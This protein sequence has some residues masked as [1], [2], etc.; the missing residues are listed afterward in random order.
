MTN[1]PLRFGLFWSGGPMSYLRYLTFKSLRHHHP[2]AQIDLYISTSFET[3]T[4][5]WIEKQDFQND[6]KDDYLPKLSELNVN[7]EKFE[8]YCDF[9]PNYQS[10]FFRWFYLKEFGGFYLDT[11]QIILKSFEDLP[12]DHDFIYCS[13][14]TQS[15]GDYYPVGV[16]G[17]NK[18]SKL[19]NEVYELLPQYTN[20]KDYN[21]LGPTMFKSVYGGKKWSEKHFNA[22]SSYFYPIAESHLTKTI[23]DGTEPLNTFNGAYA[24]HWFGGHPFSQEFNK[25]YTEEFAKDSND[26]ISQ[27]IRIINESV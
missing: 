17:A 6:I 10:D 3:E 23:Y 2:N 21:S 9:A 13:Y 19:L 5:W 1:I 18:D 24:C 16:I 20:L 14:N 12:L 11:D 15:C 8:S 22:G 27:F 26:L 4:D 7:I 25:G